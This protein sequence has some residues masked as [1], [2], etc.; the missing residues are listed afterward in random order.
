MTQ[1]ARSGTQNIPEGFKQESLAGYIK[2]SGVSRGSLEELLKDFLAFA[3]Q[4]GIRVW[5]K[6]RVESEIG[7]LGEIWEILK[8]NPTLPDNPNFPDL[9]VERRQLI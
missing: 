7:E 1:A 3:R 4:N 6:E 2:L 5:D 8:K 9:P